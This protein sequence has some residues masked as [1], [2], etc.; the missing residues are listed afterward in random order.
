[1][2]SVYQLKPAFQRGLMP[3]VAQIHAWGVSPN[4]VTLAA[5]VLSVGSG[6]LLAWVPQPRLILAGF[7]LVMLVRMGLNAVDGL[8]AKRYGLTSRLGLVLNELGDVISDGA[9]YLPFALLPGIQAAWVVPITI[10]AMLTEMTGVLGVM[11][12]SVRGYQGPMGKSDRAVVFSLIAVLLAVGVAPGLWLN[13][14]WM[15]LMGLLLWT[16][17][18]RGLSAIYPPVEGADV[19]PSSP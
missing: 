17:W 11:T 13:V 1:M 8:L 2:P 14:V 6:S 9:L 12:G 5:M 4:Q 19:T 16:I 10:L 7:P 15:V 3:L 18:N